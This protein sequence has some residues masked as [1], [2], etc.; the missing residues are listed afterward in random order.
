MLRACRGSSS[1]CRTTVLLLPA[2][3][4]LVFAPWWPLP[5]RVLAPLSVLGA[6][7][8]AFV[9]AIGYRSLVSR[10]SERRYRRRVR[11]L[12]SGGPVI[13]MPPPRHVYLANNGDTAAYEVIVT[14]G[15]EVICTGETVLPFSAP[16]GTS[17][18]SR[19]I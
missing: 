19:R 17:E 15:D 8:A 3:G 6:V 11:R 12:C 1:E 7:Y 9:Y 13:G 16:A 5:A 14:Q 4:P 10:D 2:V 18:P